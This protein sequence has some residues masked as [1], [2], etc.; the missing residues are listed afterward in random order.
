MTDK[1]APEKEIDP[2]RVTAFTG[3]R[4]VA[5]A[6][7]RVR[8]YM[9]PLL[10]MGIE[11]SERWPRFTAYPPHARVL[12]PAWL[13]ATFAQRALQIAADD[14]DVVVFQREL[15]STLPTLERWVRRPCVV[16]ID[17]AIH[18][19]RGGRPAKR[20][21]ELA[22]IV[23][24]GND[25]LAETWRQWTPSV[26]V[27][28]TAIDTDR[29][30][31]S[32]LPDRP[33]IGWIG[34]G[35]N[36]PYLHAIAPAL[37]RVVRRFPRTLIRI[38]SD[39]RPDLS[40]LPVSYVPWSPEAEVPFLASISIGVMP[41]ADGLWE[42]GKCAFKM[43]Q[44]MSTARPCVVSPAFMNTQIL[45]EADV[46]LVA[47]NLDKWAEAICDLIADPTAAQRMGVTGRKLA[48]ERYSV[49]VLAPRFAAQLLRLARV[50]QA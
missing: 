36:L 34:I 25:W 42:Q 20:L 39:V 6:R 37:R 48:E 27:I 19:F 21:A 11:L 38:C 16:D 24:V 4:N 12:R 26:E 5:A 45:R 44:Y 40:G 49:N 43:L 9:R 23:I 47:A 18:L 15:I 3:G 46:G 7:F 22:D 41:L 35:S 28:P 13:A 50:G 31:A 2:V 10:G 14:A 29:H 30:R 1:S 8:Q 32:P 33:V 17:D